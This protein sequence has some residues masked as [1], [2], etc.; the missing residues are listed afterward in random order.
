MRT[1]FITILMLLFTPL[2]FGHITKIDVQDYDTALKITYEETES[3]VEHVLYFRKADI[4]EVEL[5]G[6]DLN[7]PFIRIIRRGQYPEKQIGTIFKFKRD[8]WDQA[9]QVALR[10]VEIVFAPPEKKE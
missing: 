7:T 8:N 5:S 2:A 10:I 6:F 1:L 3:K 9:R 4:L